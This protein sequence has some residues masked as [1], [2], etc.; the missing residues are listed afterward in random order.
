M[1]MKTSINL[2][3]QNIT[4]KAVKIYKKGLYLFKVTNFQFI[5][6]GGENNKISSKC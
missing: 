3:Y 1:Q 2:L 5:L 4:N 6:N